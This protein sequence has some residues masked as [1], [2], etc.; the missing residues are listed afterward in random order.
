MTENRK[1][2]F[3]AAYSA[4]TLSPLSIYFEHIEKAEQLY[5][6]RLYDADADLLCI[7]LDEILISSANT[8]R[9]MLSLIRDY[10][11]WAIRHGYAKQEK[12]HALFYRLDYNYSQIWRNYLLDY[13]DL[14]DTL[15]TLFRDDQLETIDIV[16]KIYCELLYIGLT[17]GEV[18]ELKVSDVD[19]GKRIITLP[20]RSITLSESF[21]NRLDFDAKLTAYTVYTP[22]SSR[23]SYKK[24]K[25]SSKYLINTCRPTEG[26]REKLQ[27]ILIKSLSHAKKSEEFPRRITLEKIYVSGCMD[28][29]SRHGDPETYLI[30][31]YKRMK[32]IG[33]LSKKMLIQDFQNW[34]KARS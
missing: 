9:N 6:T 31:E 27:A 32:D 26:S 14:T 7:M 33:D 17:T 34:L 1:S 4:K 5:D 15:N 21:K 29:A 23:D 16:Y 10:I 13:N 24:Q 28:R 11:N 2:E 30:A 25:S 12:N 8:N 22:Q 18:H 20:D 3:L 19:L